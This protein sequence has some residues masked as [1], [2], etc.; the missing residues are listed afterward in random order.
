MAHFACKLGFHK[1][2]KVIPYGA[3][4]TYTNMP[5]LPVQ[6]CKYCPAI[7]FAKNY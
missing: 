6:V 1:W 5:T 4:D 3:Y 7:R 2:G